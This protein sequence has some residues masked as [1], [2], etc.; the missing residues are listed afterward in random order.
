MCPANGSS[1]AGEG[2]SPGTGAY[3]IGAVRRGLETGRGGRSP[4]ANGAT[5]MRRW[6]RT[7]GWVLAIGAAACGGQ[8]RAQTTQSEAGAGPTIDQKLAQYTSVRLTADLSGLSDRERRMIPLLIQAVQEMDTHLLAAGVSR[9]RLAARRDS[10]QRHPRL[11]PAQLRSL[12]PARRQCTV[13]SRCRAS[14]RWCRVLS[15]RHVEGGVRQRG[16]GQRGGG[17]GASWPLHRRT[18]RFVRP[19]R[20]RALPRRPTPSRAAGRP[21]SCARPPRSRTTRGSSA[22]SS[23]AR[24]PSRPTTT[25]RAIWPGW[26]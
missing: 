9:P 10:R 23:F 17:S 2:F 4:T 24:P 8:D 18:A 22:T 19:A 3:R 26:T 1:R 11:R 7:A 20:H 16:Q 14:A 6:V 5:R 13:R 15:E 12:G 21:P 25:S